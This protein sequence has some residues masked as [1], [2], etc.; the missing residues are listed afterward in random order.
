MSSRL[1][2]YI[3]TTVLEAAALIGIARF[4]LPRFGINISLVW[5]LVILIAWLG[6]SVFMYRVMSQTLQR[7]LLDNLTSM[8][9]SRGMVITPLKP[10][11]WIRIKG[12]LWKAYAEDE[13]GDVGEEV[14]VVGQDRLKLIVRRP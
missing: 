13:M 14:V 11:G 3:V 10:E 12:E 1:I 6:H 5:L 4:L 8:V 7:K 9:G 2:V